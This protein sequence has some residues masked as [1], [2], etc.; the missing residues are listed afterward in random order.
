MAN[1]HCYDNHNVSHP[2]YQENNFHH[3][4]QQTTHSRSL[5]HQQLPAG[6][7]RTTGPD[8]QV[9]DLSRSSETSL[10][11]MSGVDTN[12]LGGYYSTPPPLYSELIQRPQETYANHFSYPCKSESTY[13]LGWGQSLHAQEFATRSYFDRLDR[14]GANEYSQEDDQLLMAGLDDHTPMGLA[15]AQQLWA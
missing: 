13:S 15:H 4:G 2:E 14:H 10:D 7:L 8:W 1:G 5:G 3:F 6:D 11:G 12:E 9:A